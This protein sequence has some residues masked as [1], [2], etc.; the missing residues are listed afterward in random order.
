MLALASL[1]SCVP[2]FQLPNDGVKIEVQLWFLQNHTSVRATWTGTLARVTEDA[3]ALADADDD[4]SAALAGPIDVQGPEL[5]RFPVVDDLV[6]GRWDITITIREG[7]TVLASLTC[8]NLAIGDGAY[9]LE[10]PYIVRWVE[11]GSNECVADLGMPDPEPPVRDAEVTSMSALPS[12]DFGALVPITVSVSS[13]SDF[14]ENIAVRLTMQPPTGAPVSFQEQI[15]TVVPSGSGQVTFNWNSACAGPPGIYV[16]NA[17]AFVP[18]DSNTANDSRSRSINMTADREIRLSNLTGPATVQKNRPG[19]T[20][21]TVM[22]SNSGSQAETGVDIRFTD[23]SSSGDPT[24]NSVNWL[25]DLPPWN[26]TC[27]ESAV[28]TFFHFPNT[29]GAGGGHTYTLTLSPAAPIPGD[30]PTDNVVS[31][32]VTEVP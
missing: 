22:V 19:G 8:R 18:T 7:S 2:N 23:T 24:S 29:A 3:G 28:R 25:G 12:A 13:H 17:S 30:N 15:A 4:A 32:Q 27:G 31:I 11:D 20:Q 5:V 21:F 6:P 10:H 16:F 26:L 14:T 9:D 1:T